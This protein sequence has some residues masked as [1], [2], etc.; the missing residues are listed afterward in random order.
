MKTNEDFPFAVDPNDHCESPLNAYED[1]RPILDI[2]V[3]LLGR[4]TNDQ[5]SI[6]DPYYCNGLTLK[7]LKDLGYSNV[8]NKYV[9]F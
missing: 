5:L 7:H 4:K 8:Y 6:Y 1:I 9:L 2:L 3:Q